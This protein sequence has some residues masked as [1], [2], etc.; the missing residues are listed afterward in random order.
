M[1]QQKADM[2]VGGST[3][4]QV[5]RRKKLD[6]SRGGE[7]D[8]K[9]KIK[10]TERGPVK[11]EH[12]CR[13]RVNRTAIEAKPNW[14]FESLLSEVDS[15]EEKLSWMPNFSDIR[16]KINQMMFLCFQIPASYCSQQMTE[17]MAFLAYN[18]ALKL[19][20]WWHLAVN[21]VVTVADMK[22][23]QPMMFISMAKKKKLSRS[24]VD[25]LSK[26]PAHLIQLILTPLPIK[27]AGRTSI[28][29]REWRHHWRSITRLVFDDEFFDSPGYNSDD[30]ISA[31]KLMSN[32][33]ETLQVHD[34]PITEFVLSNPELVTT[35]KIGP[36]ISHLSG[37][38]VSD[39]SLLYRKYFDSQ[40]FE[41][42]IDSSL[43]H[44]VQLD[45]LSL[46]GCKFTVPSWFMGFARLTSLQLEHVGLPDDFFHS[47]LL[48]CPLLEDLRVFYFEGPYNLELVAPPCLKVFTLMAFGLGNISIKYAP[49]LSVVSIQAEEIAYKSLA[50]DMVSAFASLPSLEQLYISSECLKLMA[51]DPI[52]YRLP[53]ALHCLKVLDIRKYDKDDSFL[54]QEVLLW[55]IRSSPNLYKLTIQMQRRGEL[56]FTRRDLKLSDYEPDTD[57]EAKDGCCQ[58]LEEV[59]IMLG[60]GSQVELDLLRFVLANGPLLRRIVIEPVKEMSWEGCLEFLEE[61]RQY[62]CASKKAEIIYVNE[63]NRIVF[64][65]RLANL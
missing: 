58:R 23:C 54:K 27:E 45:R 32:V 43:F 62:E 8:Q 36:L 14:S 51:A 40:V 26:L 3:N 59:N 10:A 53:T 12:R 49:L 20:L 30:E 29:S 61:I 25:R 37:K 47:F 48:K 57:L 11:L 64:R 38:G 24:K 60:G 17:E 31:N 52:P 2:G 1:E 13:K 21:D 50:T 39:L 4:V 19:I 63:S 34:G 15:F 35:V 22:L 7:K 5:G 28:L 16:I 65:T 55:L 33:Q 42:E 44:A 41:Q 18:R 9:A 56:H 6:G 46:E